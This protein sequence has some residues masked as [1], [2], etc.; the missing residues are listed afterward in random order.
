MTERSSVVFHRLTNECRF[1]SS[2]VTEREREI[3]RS[4]SLGNTSLEIAT[5]LF[6]SEHTV[7]SHR[8][9][10]MSKLDAR[11]S[12]HLIMKGVKMGLL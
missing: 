3:L 8:K 10:L 6:I 5:S 9:N 7:I 1:L 12:A 11:N 4:M 2:L